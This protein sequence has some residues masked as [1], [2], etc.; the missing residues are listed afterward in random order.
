MENSRNQQLWKKAKRRASF[1][2][3]LRSYVM[4]NGGLWII[5]FLTTGQHW[6]H[7]MTPW[8]IWPMLGWGIGLASHYFAA[9]GNVDETNMVQK[10]YDK[11]LREQR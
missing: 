1:K 5:Y 3:H 7:E 2:I 8:P 6:T 10:E 9:Y 4:V 11:L